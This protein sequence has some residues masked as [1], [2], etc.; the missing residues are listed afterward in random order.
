MVDALG[1]ACLLLGAFLMLSGGVGVLR[2]PDFFTRM[3]AAGVTETLATT[4]ILFGLMLIAGWNIVSFKL[5]LILLFIMITSPVASHALAK[6][7]LH[8]KLQPL[9]DERDEQ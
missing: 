1:S 8:G 9:V 2:F 4:L 5:V 6:A 3:H 7:A